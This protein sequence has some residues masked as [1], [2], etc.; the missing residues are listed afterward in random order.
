MEP[1][2]AP[3]KPTPSPQSQNRPADPK[4]TDA[5]AQSLLAATTAEFNARQANKPQTKHFL[6]KKMI[7]FLVASVIMTIL[8]WGIAVYSS[9]RNHNAEAQTNVHTQE[10]LQQTRQLNTEVNTQTY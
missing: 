7:I 5:Y 3:P 6:S 4:M 1:V 8:L 2:P 10:L 9:R